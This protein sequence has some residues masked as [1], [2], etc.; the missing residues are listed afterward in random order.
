LLQVLRPSVFIFFNVQGP[1]SNADR[2]TCVRLLADAVAP[3]I[4][5]Y[6]KEIALPDPFERVP[7]SVKFRTGTTRLPVVDRSPLDAL[8]LSF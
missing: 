3:A 2:Q 6:A 4:R 1:V 5:D 7:G 8:G